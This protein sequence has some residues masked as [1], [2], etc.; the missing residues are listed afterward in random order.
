MQTESQSPAATAAE[1]M[2]PG[3][4]SAATALLS[5]ASLI[6]FSSGCAGYRFGSQSLYNTNLRTIYVPMVRNDSWR[7]DIN[8]QLTEALVKAI[9]LHTPYK[10]VADPNA[11]STLTC[12]VIASGKRTV[13]E[14]ITDEP[15]AIED[16]MTVQLT[17][18]DRRGNLLFTNRFLPEGELAYHFTQATDFVPEGG[19]SLSTAQQRTIERL[20]DQIVQQMEMRW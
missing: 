4:L 17:W 15:R 9:E 2:R 18:T 16:Q 6:C 8:Q 10:V 1:S 5:L 20:A 12:R 14:A 3:W 13:A 11:D 19:Q 7:H